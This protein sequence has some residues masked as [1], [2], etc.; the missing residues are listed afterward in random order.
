MYKQAQQEQ[1]GSQEETPQAGAEAES[2]V[3][4]DKSDGAVEADF[5]VVDAEDD[6]K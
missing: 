6:K 4:S 2:D 5:E 3:G 1:A